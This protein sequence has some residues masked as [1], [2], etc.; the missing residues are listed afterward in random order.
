MLLKFSMVAELNLECYRFVCK[1]RIYIL[2]ILC[3]QKTFCFGQSFSKCPSSSVHT[4][5]CSGEL[6]PKGCMLATLGTRSFSAAA[7]KFWNSPL[8]HI[9][10][11]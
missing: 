4:V 3:F 7:P 2:R 5:M 8:A 1:K 6:F 9:H 10:D 11:I